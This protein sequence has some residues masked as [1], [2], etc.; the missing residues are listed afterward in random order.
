MVY[1]LCRVKVEMNG[2]EKSIPL[3]SGTRI[4][5]LLQQ[6][7]SAFN[8]PTQNRN[9]IQLRGPSGVLKSTDVIPPQDFSDTLTLEYSSRTPSQEKPQSAS[10]SASKTEAKESTITISYNKDDSFP[11]ACPYDT[12]TTVRDLLIHYLKVVSV[13][14]LKNRL[15]FPRATLTTIRRACAFR[16][17]TRDWTIRFSFRTTSLMA[18]FTFSVSSVHES[19]DLGKRRNE[20]V[21]IFPVSPSRSLTL[22]YGDGEDY[23]RSVS[24]TN[25]D[26]VRDLLE[27]YLQV[28]V[29][30]CDEG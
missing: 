11:K 29:L 16:A 4:Q 22:A 2:N 7:Y 25:Q 27:R 8:I 12:K 3:Y 10:A 18:P 21:A 17:T 14:D 26:S 13:P 9:Q 20:V 6:C 23:V 1:V 5:S 24:V 28:R 19:D 15:F 30:C